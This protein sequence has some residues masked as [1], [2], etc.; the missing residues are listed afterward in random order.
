[1]GDRAWEG[2]L[3]DEGGGEAGIQ[4]VFG[5]REEVVMKKREGYTPSGRIRQALRLL[6]LR[7]RER[8]AA[9]KATGYRC[10]YCGVKQSV[11]KG[12]EVRL[13]VHHM[14]GVDW[15]GLI[16]LVRERL[17]QRAERLAPACKECHAKEGA[18]GEEAKRCTHG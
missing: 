17:L 15:E 3:Q 6:W 14:D 5:E 11:A 9:L 2:A 8:Q 16:E 10:A 18:K 1:M 13:E 7:S 4:A 12:K